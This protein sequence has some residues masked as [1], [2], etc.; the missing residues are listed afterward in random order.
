MLKPIGYI[1][2]VE[3]LPRGDAFTIVYTDGVTVQFCFDCAVPENSKI[4]GELVYFFG[5]SHN[6]FILVYGDSN[7]PLWLTGGEFG[8][9]YMKDFLKKLMA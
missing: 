6:R 8:E 4:E 7:D 5:I 9:E 2:S 3:H 1:H